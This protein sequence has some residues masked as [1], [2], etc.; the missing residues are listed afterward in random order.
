MTNGFKYSH[1]KGKN[2]LLYQQLR[3]ARSTKRII[4]LLVLCFFVI[5]LGSRGLSKPLPLGQSSNK[6]VQIFCDDENDR[7][8]SLPGSNRQWSTV[9]TDE[10]LR[11][12]NT[13]KPSQ[14]NKQSVRNLG[15]Y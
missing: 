11:K 8:Q 9:P 5:P 13:S 15:S 4:T 6:P 14:W 3:Q 2:V 12:E 7:G 1:Q 10:E